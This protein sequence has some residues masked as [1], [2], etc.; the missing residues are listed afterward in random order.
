MRILVTGGVG[1]NGSWVTRKLL[2]R[3][4][5]PIVLDY[6]VDYSLLPDLEGQFELVTGDITQLEP[7]AAIVKAKKVERIAHMAAY[8]SPTMEEE[9]YHQFLINGMGSVN[10][11]EA[12]RLA[13]V[14]RVIYTSSRGYYGETPRGVGEPGYVP[15]AEDTPPRARGIY[16]VSKNAAEGMGRNYARVYGIEFA[17]LRFAGIYGPG[18]QARH[19]FTS[20]RSKMVEDPFEGKPFHLPDG[21]DQLDDMIFVDDVAEAIVTA[22]LA[23]KLGFDAYNIAS[24]EGHTLREFAAA[25]KNEIPGAD[26]EVGPG[27]RQYG[28]HHNYAIFDISRAKADLGWAPRYPIPAGVKAYVETLRVRAA[29][30]K[31][32]A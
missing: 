31:A 25:I 12:A 22:L 4:H 23:P 27:T 32:P 10:M 24:G 13:G 6:R 18:K 1:V 14:G 7:L 3:G 8:L 28:P 17:A 16:D 2:E 19:S 30:E 9:P 26:V 20:L 5:E 15:I 21:G 11:L 29:G